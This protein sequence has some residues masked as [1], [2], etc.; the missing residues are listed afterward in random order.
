MR[1]LSLA[2][3][4]VTHTRPRGSRAA[5]TACTALGAMLVLSFSA[6]CDKVPLTAPT[7]SVITL[8][9]AASIMPL[10][11]EVEIV[12]TVIENG[13]TTTSGTGPGTGTTSSTTPGAGTPVQNGT[14]I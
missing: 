5:L 7:G 12:A 11:G 3:L 6:A 13:T 1:V 14:L 10:N 2:S 4:M 9:A 8:F